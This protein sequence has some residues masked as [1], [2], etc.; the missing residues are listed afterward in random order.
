MGLFRKTPS[1]SHYFVIAVLSLT[2]IRLCASRPRQ[3]SGP[4]Y[5]KVKL[6]AATSKCLALLC[7][8]SVRL[9]NGTIAVRVSAVLD[10]LA[11]NAR[12]AVGDDGAL[13]QPLPSV[14]VDIFEI[15]GM[16]VTRDIAASGFHKGQ[17]YNS[18]RHPHK[19]TPIRSDRC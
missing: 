19:R 18:G 15:E 14:V 12:S 2:S 3:R 5:S 6:P 13:S 10:I 1:E 8:R 7:L 17:K 16:D 4:S 11:I 9:H